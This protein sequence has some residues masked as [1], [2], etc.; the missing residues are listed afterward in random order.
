MKY[1]M[2]DNIQYNSYL[3][4]EKHIGDKI[5]NPIRNRIGHKVRKLTM[6][7]IWIN[8][9]KNFRY[10]CDIKEQLSESINHI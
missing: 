9:A 3:L 2:G 5:W 4:M 10:I 1:L 6:R 8:N 7:N